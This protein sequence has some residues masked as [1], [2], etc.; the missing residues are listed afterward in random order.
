VLVEQFVALWDRT[1]EVG[2][3]TDPALR[4]ALVNRLAGYAARYRAHDPCYGTLINAEFLALAN[5]LH[6]EATQEQT[7]MDRRG[8]P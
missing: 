8:D 6:D 2:I 4:S 7:V 5:L 3:Q 1:V